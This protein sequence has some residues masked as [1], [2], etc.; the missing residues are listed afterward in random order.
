MVLTD[1]SELPASVCVLAI[2]VIPNTEFLNGVVKM[3]KRGHVEV[4]EVS[5]CVKCV[6]LLKGRGTLL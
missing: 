4:D 6:S 1:D 2:G 3:D 5:A